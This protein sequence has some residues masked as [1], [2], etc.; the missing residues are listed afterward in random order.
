MLEIKACDLH[1]KSHSRFSSIIFKVLYFKFA[2]R[3]L[4]VSF[5]LSCKVC[6]YISFVVPNCSVVRVA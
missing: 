6:S 3:Q 5:G 4:G 1:E 2:F